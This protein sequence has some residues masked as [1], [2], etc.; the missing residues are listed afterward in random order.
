M[1]QALKIMFEA[2][3]IAVVTGFMISLLIQLLSRFVQLRRSG[4]MD[5][6]AKIA[7]AVA[8]AIR[9]RGQMK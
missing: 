6:S 2:A 8:A 3:A 5:D 4:D 9:Q 1:I 7:L